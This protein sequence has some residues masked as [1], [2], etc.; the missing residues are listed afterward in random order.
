M[1]IRSLLIA[2]SLFF[3]AA[4]P[5]N[6]NPGRDAVITARYY[7]SLISAPLPRLAELEL[8]TNMMPKGGDL[9][10]HYDGSLYA[11]NYLDWAQQH[12]WCIY[13]ESDT[14]LKAEKFRV[15]MKPQELPKAARKICVDAA[16]ARNDGVFYQQ[17]LQRWSVKD[18]GNHGHR[19]LPPDQ[20]FFNTFQHFIPLV[21][22]SSP[23]GLQILKQ[24]AL[25]ENVQYLESV[26][27]MAPVVENPLLAA[28]INALDAASGEAQVEAA[29]SAY[30]D[31]IAHDP[32]AR[33]AIRRYVQMAEQA[34]A[35]IDDERFTLR[36]HAFVFRG[37]EPASVFS[38]MA[39]AFAAAQASGRIVGVNIV[40]AENS[41]VAMR[42]YTLQ[43][44]MFRFL[45]RQYPQVKLSLHAGELALGMVPPEGLRH[46]IRD[47]LL[48]AGADR[49]G[50]G[51]DIAH[52]TDA[53]DTLRLMR[54]RRIPVEINLSSNAFIL[55]L[56]GEAHPLPLYR[57]QRVPFIIASDDTGV[58][59]NSLSREYLLF[60]S[61]YRPS[62]AQLK[63]AVY[64]TIRHSFLTDGEKRAQMAQ[65]AQRFAAFE[66]QMAGMAQAGGKPGR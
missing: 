51:A 55:G 33:A 26:F 22:F 31:F 58:S 3:I 13:R 61:R 34:A 4:I 14:A 62:Y 43:M 19:Q 16:A 6:A 37:G 63:E 53:L 2:F 17:L 1:N 25:A 20:H 29:L 60:A 32:Q 50:H 27:A 21:D 41:P 18:Y 24:R 47:A 38:S 12:G 59:R 15:E 35:G 39:T 45:K 28:K 30:A 9:H 40:G 10:Q 57:Q 5:V 36:L 8:F 49:I 66:R 48:I 46:H 23:V 44:K 56:Q 64:N 42:D 52:E 65:L 7:Q 54:E 11:E